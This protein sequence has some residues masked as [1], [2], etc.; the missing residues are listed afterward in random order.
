MLLLPV[1]TP[2]QAAAWDARAER[3]GTPARALMESAGRAVAALLAGRYAERLRFGVLVACGPG[4]NGGD[5]WVVARALHAAGVPVWVAA[6]GEPGGALPRAMASLAREA[7]VRTVQADGP[8]PNV[9]LAVDALL[10]TGATGA[11][12]G[13][14]AALLARV[15]DLER[16]VIAVDGPSGLDLADGVQHGPLRATLTVTFGGYRRGHLLARDDVGDLAVVDIGFPGPD[17][18]WPVFLSE[19]AAADLVLPFAA[20]AHK[21]SRGRVVVVGGDDGMLGA[22]RLTA[23][24]VFA[25]GAGLVHLVAPTASV[26]IIATAEPDLQTCAQP[27]E[28]HPSTRTTALLGR[29]DAVV[30]GP[31]LGRSPSR[32]DFVLGILL[33]APPE[34]A[35]VLDADG[36]MAFAGQTDRLRDGLAGRRAVLTPHA[37]EFRTL[38]PEEASRVDVDPWGAAEAAAVRIGAAVLLKGVPTVIAVAGQPTVTVAAGNPGLATGGSGDMLSGLV[39]A[40]AAQGLAPEAA[41]G[42]G[43]V[44]LGEAADLAARRV[45]ARAMRPM[46]VLAALPDVWRRWDRLRRQPPPPRPP[47]LHELPAPQRV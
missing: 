8:W 12:R 26:T 38:F 3:C 41:G 34:A 25:A 19:A 31:G 45:T 24:S 43:A 17:P 9:G 44:A 16:P 18:G 39:A 10:G 11:P 47:I 35:I 4:N 15:A 36:L 6:S 29:A 7:G 5:G 46:D 30:V 1:L 42:A 13:A 21:G 40:F 23:R 28:A 37:G 14:V 22:A 33:A 32:A 2:S 27:F 20:D